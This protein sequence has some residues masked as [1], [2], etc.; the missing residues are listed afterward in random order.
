MVIRV[1]Q[2][3]TM[4]GGL[5]CEEDSSQAGNNITIL[6]DNGLRGL[7]TKGQITGI[8]PRERIFASRMMGDEGYMVTFRQVDPLYTIDLSDHS[9]PKTT[10]LKYYL[11]IP[12]ICIPSMTSICWLW[13]WMEKKMEH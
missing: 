12:H 8:A 9:D 13:A 2:V 6:Q 5:S 3:R 4:T 11:A 7:Q 1:W 10:E